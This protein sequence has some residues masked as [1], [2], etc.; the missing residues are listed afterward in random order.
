MAAAGLMTSNKTAKRFFPSFF[1]YF[2][3]AARHYDLGL[4]GFLG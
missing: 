1:F 3:I 2:S 4:H